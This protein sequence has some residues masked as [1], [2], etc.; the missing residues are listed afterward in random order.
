MFLP[1]AKVMRNKVLKVKIFNHVFLI[2]S[3]RGLIRD[4]ITKERSQF[5]IDL[6]FI[7]HSLRKLANSLSSSRFLLI[8]KSDEPK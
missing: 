5:V 2:G 1:E 7:G 4:K 3:K 8:S 6:S